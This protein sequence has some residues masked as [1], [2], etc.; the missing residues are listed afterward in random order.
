MRKSCFIVFIICLVGVKIY[1]QSPNMALQKE[2]GGSS[3]DQLYS[4]RQTSDGGFIAGGISSSIASGDKA[5][6]CWGAY[7]YWVVKMDNAGNI[8]W[9]KDIGGDNDD[10]LRM[11]QQT[12]DG[13]YIIG[14]YSNSDSSGTKT[15]N[16]VSGAFSYDYD[17]WIVK[18]DNTGNIQ[19]QKDIGG[20]GNDYL[21]A[22]E[23]TTDA[24]YIL[25]GYSNSDSS[26]D[27]TMAS[28]GGD[29]YWIIKLDSTG[30]IMWQKDFGGDN[31]DGLS[32]FNYSSISI[33]QTTD[34][35]YI[36]GGSSNSDSSGN[37]TTNP[38]GGV[39]SY[40]FDYWILKLD[41]TGNIQWQKDIG[42]T[43]TDFLYSVKQTTDGGYIVGGS[44]NSGISGDKTLPCWGTYNYW[45][46]KLDNSGN[47]QWQ[48]NLG[49][50]GT[51]ILSSFIQT[52]D[53]GYFVA[54]TSN[55]DSSG[56]K[57]TNPWGG[58]KSMDYDYWA[59]SL[60]ASG[61]IIWQKDMGGAN[62]DQALAAIET[63]DTAFVLGGASS[64]DA[65]GNKAT[66]NYGLEND[67]WIV[68]LKACTGITIVRTVT[69][70]VCPGV[71]YVLPGPSGNIVYSLGTFN[72]SLVSLNGCDSIIIL[73]LVNSIDTTVTVSGDTLTANDKSATYQWVDCLSGR[74]IPG[75]TNASFVPTLNDIYQVILTKN[76]C[77]EHSA[78]YTIDNVGVGNLILDDSLLVYP[79]P[80]NGI[81]NISL[82]GN[83][84]QTRVQV[85]NLT[86]T[87]ILDK[88]YDQPLIKIDM[89]S[90]AA[91]VYL[92]KVVNGNID[93]QVKIIKTE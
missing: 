43:Q 11:I 71:G 40:D 27:K 92:L 56:N 20:T 55:S 21:N 87:V 29:D 50:D 90:A 77:T 3:D 85:L 89:Q 57:T 38:A 25:A 10:E 64:S 26:G 30:N 52:Q 37:K 65:S 86:G 68:K 32:L 73:S 15:S 4:I 28:N 24:G 78:C 47:I 13:G 79:N 76:G 51:D 59:L 2:L 61:N 70:S 88:I 93:K 39:S 66:H 53:G 58:A 46:L 81:L 18:L 42:G 82:G 17:Y 9:Q 41:N 1:A 45:V 6:T 54:G 31:S 67:Y 35:G 14:G 7:N 74:A 62:S 69:D 84:A 5:D 49:G 44:S 34:G 8:Q 48:Q 83:S 16:P 36:L 12:T 19:W 80:T 72:D 23:Q 63:A 33:D 22:I 60:D 75:D 91:G